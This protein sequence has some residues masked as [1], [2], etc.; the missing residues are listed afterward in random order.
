[1]KYSK[2]FTFLTILVSILLAGCASTTSPPPAETSQVKVEASATTTAATPSQVQDDGPWQVVLQTEYKQPMRMAA[3]F[4]ENTGY[5]SGPQAN[6]VHYTSDGG[7][8]WTK[9]ESSPYCVFGLNIVD[10]QTVWLCALDDQGLSTDGGQTWQITDGGQTWRIGPGVGGNGCLLSFTNAST[11]WILDSKKLRVTV[12]SGQTWEDVTVPENDVG[13]I[14]AIS[15]RAP[16]EGYVLDFDGILHTTQ[17]GGKNWSSH[18]LDLEK[19]EGLKFMPIALSTATMRFFDADHGLIVLNLMSGEGETKVVALHT[20]DGGQTWE[21]E[22]VTNDIGNLHLSP[23][24]K[25]LTITSYLNS[26]TI[27][28]FRYNES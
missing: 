14:A 28:V 8:T 25:V 23:D 16:G 2:T 1:M 13:N 4:D 7:Q 17:D 19:Y 18:I 15:L 6:K 12:D 20:A 24:G 21:D 3:F 9:A 26:S 27:T 10:A 11:G 5:T 22:V